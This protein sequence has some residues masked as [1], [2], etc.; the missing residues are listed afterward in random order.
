M[1]FRPD[2]LPIYRSSAACPTSDRGRRRG[3]RVDGAARGRR[4]V[5]P[6]RA[7]LRHQRC[8]GRGAA[9]PQPTAAGQLWPRGDVED[10][11]LLLGRLRLDVDPGADLGHRA[12][13]RCR[14]RR[15]RRDRA[16]PLARREFLALG[17]TGAPGDGAAGARLRAQRRE[18]DPLGDGDG[19]ALRAAALPHHRA[20]GRVDGLGLG[21]VDGPSRRTLALWNTNSDEV[22]TS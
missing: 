4:V 7:P 15:R 5:S 9:L 18:P 20:V 12:D 14:Q 2:G 8:D 1:G 21:A 22:N 3:L 11:P 19:R 6:Q 10:L 13:R 16:L 17:A